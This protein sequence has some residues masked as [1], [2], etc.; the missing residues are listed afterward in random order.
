MRQSHESW[1]FTD[2]QNKTVSG[3]TNIGATADNV[4]VCNFVVNSGVWYKMSVA[5]A[6][7]VVISTCNQANFDTQIAIYIGVCGSLVCKTDADDTE[8][9]DLTTRVIYD[10]EPQEIYIVVNGYETGTGN[11]DLT[12][13]IT[14]TLLVIPVSQW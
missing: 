12:I 6:A 13:S 1:F 4:F 5:F 2:G 9:C 14:A 7:S 3:Q 8:G 11:F 10:M